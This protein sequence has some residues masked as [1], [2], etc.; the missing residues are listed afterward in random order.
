[1]GYEPKV[2]R[3]LTSSKRAFTGCTIEG[4]AKSTAVDTSSVARQVIMNFII[5]D[6]L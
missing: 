5:V 1:V 3:K 2:R 4:R 6:E